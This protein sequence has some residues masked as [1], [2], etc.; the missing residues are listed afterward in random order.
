MPLPLLFLIVGG[1][2]MA[3][4]PILLMAHITQNADEERRKVGRCH[5]G[6]E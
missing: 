1:V 2:F 6:P 5:F 3:G 4:L